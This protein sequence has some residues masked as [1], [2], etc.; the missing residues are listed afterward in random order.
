MS[1][2]KIPKFFIFSN[3]HYAI[4]LM[5]SFLQHCIGCTPM[6]KL[7]ILGKLKFS[8]SL[9]TL[10]P[11]LPLQHCIMCHIST[12]VSDLLTWKG[13]SVWKC[14]SSTVQSSSR[15]LCAACSVQRA[16]CSVQYLTYAYPISVHWREPGRTGPSASR[17]HAGPRWRGV[18]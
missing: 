8:E 16:A 17:S 7:K 15:G 2:K 1:G 9:R 11:Y 13:S 3:R 14:N 4:M 18:C 6:P 5:V 10:L 12:T